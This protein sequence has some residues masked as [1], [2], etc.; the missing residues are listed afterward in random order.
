MDEIRSNDI[1]W[2]ES[3][4]IQHWIIWKILLSKG[5]PLHGRKTTGKE[6][7]KSQCAWQSVTI[8]KWFEKHHRIALACIRSYRLIGFVN[9]C[10]CIAIGNTQFWFSPYFC[11]RLHFARCLAVYWFVC[12]LPISDID[13]LTWMPDINLKIPFI[14]TCACWYR[15]KLKRLCGCGCI[16]ACKRL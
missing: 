6:R 10:R 3:Q 7:K 2:N 1:I 11:G 4:K 16:S 5:E 12:H 15:P 9:I 8:W 14:Y 13:R